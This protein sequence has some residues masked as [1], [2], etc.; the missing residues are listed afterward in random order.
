MAERLA[1][2][3]RAPSTGPGISAPVFEDLKMV[4]DLP[5][6]TLQQ[7]GDELGRYPGFLSPKTQDEIISGCVDGG[8]AD[9][10]SRLGNVIR[11]GELFLRE[12]KG[13]FENLL[14]QMERWRQSGDTRRS[15]SLTSEQLSQLK[16][17]LP[18][19]IREYPSRL[20]QLKAAR[21]A[22]A[23]GLRAESV[24]LICDLRPVLDESR[25]EIIGVIPITTLKIVASGVDQ[26]PIAF[27]AILSAKDVQELLKEAESAVKELNVLGEFAAHNHIKIPAVDLTETIEDKRGA[28]A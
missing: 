21:L 4:L 10:G 26:F 6:D 2:Y 3:F 18:L 1:F 8:H 19:L 16:D 28:D 14:S 9:T 13:G 7:I 24:D 17:R 11:F 15:E 12:N 27:E 25:S 20:R 5:I 22:E 23:T